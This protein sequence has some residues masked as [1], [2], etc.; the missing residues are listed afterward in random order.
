MEEFY[1]ID[2]DDPEGRPVR[3]VGK[4]IDG[5]KRFRTYQVGENKIRGYKTRRQAR[6]SW[7][8]YRARG[9]I[10]QAKKKVAGMTRR[11][12]EMCRPPECR[13]Y[14][15]WCKWIIIYDGIPPGPVDC[16]AVD[17][18]WDAFQKNHA[19]MVQVVRTRERE[20]NT[21]HPSSKRRRIMH[22]LMQIDETELD[23]V[24]N[25]LSVFTQS[26]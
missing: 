26:T 3:H 15:D 9:I 21:E 25:A 6:A 10:R 13:S 7:T 8:D 17:R 24:E 22:A 19:T 16:V 18:Y 20:Q 14:V 12:I 2:H 4:Y 11:E 5:E 23:N 1:T